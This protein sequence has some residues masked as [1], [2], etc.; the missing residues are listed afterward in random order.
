MLLQPEI[1]MSVL[2]EY[3]QGI[4]SS[5]IVV[6]CL[7]SLRAGVAQFQRLCGDLQVPLICALA[8]WCGESPGR[9]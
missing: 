9:C 3:L 7:V 4:L 6:E 5:A 2:G 1:A 8:S